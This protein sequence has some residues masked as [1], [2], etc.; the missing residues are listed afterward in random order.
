MLEHTSE[1]NQVLVAGTVDSP[2]VFA[3]EIYGEGF[4]NFTLAVPRLSGYV[5][6]IPVTVSERLIDIGT[7]PVGAK[8]VIKGQF[9]SYNKYI[10]GKNRL[11]LTV[12]AKDI[13]MKEEEYR[14]IRNPNQI[15]LDGYICKPPVYR[16]TPL[17]REIAD[18]LLAVN[19]SYN[20][21]DYIPVIL[22]GRNARFSENLAV[23]QRIRIWGRIQSRPYQK[24]L[25]NGEI[26]DKI[27][28]EVSVSKLQVVSEQK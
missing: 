4:Y 19:R 15:Y 16:T 2:P 17:N 18:V 8:V 27:A 7:L 25:P 5:D 11:I 12:F 1:N 14:G 13:S 24:K 10:D 23:G 20:K 3:H 22:W 28:Y 26:Q 9:R 21:S 6:V